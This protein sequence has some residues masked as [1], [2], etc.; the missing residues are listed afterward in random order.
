MFLDSGIN[1][2]EVPQEQRNHLSVRTEELSQKDRRWLWE[3]EK[4]RDEMTLEMMQLV[5]MTGP[6]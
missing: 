5:V 4:R 2:L 3:R 6:R 1:G